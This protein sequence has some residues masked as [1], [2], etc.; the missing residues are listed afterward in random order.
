MPDTAVEMA[1]RMRVT[2]APLSA[3]AE[4]IRGAAKPAST[5]RPDAAGA[6]NR[7]AGS[8]VTLLAFCE[9]LERSARFLEDAAEAFE[10][11]KLTGQAGQFR[12][13]AQLTRRLSLKIGG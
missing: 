6:P 3:L 11:L 4:T 2:N 5:T 8:S 1:R 12:V 7:P 13:Q 10:A 9:H